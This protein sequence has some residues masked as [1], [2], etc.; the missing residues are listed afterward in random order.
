MK[1]GKPRYS[2]TEFQFSGY[3]RL[4][5]VSLPVLGGC[6][7]WGRSTVRGTATPACSAMTL[8]RNLS[9]A[10]HQKGLLTI[11]TPLAASVFR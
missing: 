6:F 5:K 10:D 2:K 8:S 1:M 3:S 7:L 11:C 9:S 4:V